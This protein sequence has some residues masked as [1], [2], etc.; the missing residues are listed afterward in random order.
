[1]KV[2]FSSNKNPDFITITEYIENALS[3]KSKYAFFNDRDFIVPGRIRD[4]FPILNKLDLLRI[5]K[6]LLSLTEKFKPDIF[7]EAGGY[8]I[9]PQTIEKIKE[10]GIKTVLWTIDVPKYFESIIEASHYYDFVF[11][12]GSEA[13]EIL[14]NYNLKNLYWLPFAC[15]PEFHKPVKITGGEKALYENDIV[16]VGS[17][18][19]NRMRVL[20]EI[21]D[22][23]LGVWGPG[24]EKVPPVSSL[25]RRIRRAGGVKSDEWIKIYTSCKI[26]IAIHYRDEDTPC[27]QASPKIYEV[28]AC[29]C[30]LLVDN[31]R[32]VISLFDDGKHLLIF[33]SIVDLREKIKYYLER[34]EE[35]VSIAEEGYKEVIQQHTYSHRINKMIQI[36]KNRG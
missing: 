22:F 34:S 5:N 14:K 7:F 35:R 1:M 27:Y 12:G 26:A 28:L 31:Q 30:F 8:R 24:W 20:E 21:S 18:Y 33:E 23:D 15:D 17:Y 32:D 29:K 6:N 9:L 25:K 19:P 36:I 2:L 11:T 13:I 10:M 4:N 3:K 16:F